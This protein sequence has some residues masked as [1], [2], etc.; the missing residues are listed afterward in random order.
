MK[1]LIVDDDTTNQRILSAYLKTDGNWVVLAKNGLEAVEL[2]Q[3]ESPELILM[4]VIMP[5]MDGYEATK[6]IKSMMADRF[7]PIIFLTPTTDE[8]VLTRCIEVGGDDFLTKPYNRTL[9]TAKID[10]L[11]RVNQLYNMVYQ[12]KQALLTHQALEAKEHEVARKVFD[13][14]LSSGCLSVENIQ[15]HLSPMSLFNGDVVLAAVKPTG[16]MHILLGDFTGHGLAASLGALPLS[17]VFYSMTSKGYSISDMVREINHKL[18]V[19]LPIGMFLAACLIEIDSHNKVLKYWNGAIPGAFLQKGDVLIE[20]CSKNLPLGILDD[21]CFIDKVDLIELNDQDRIILSTD[22]ILEAENN[23]GK[24]FGLARFKACLHFDDN[25]PLLEP[26]LLAKEADLFHHILETLGEFTQQQAQTDD[27]TLAVINCDMDYINQLESHKGAYKRFV[28]SHWEFSLTFYYDAIKLID[29]IP[30]INQI[31]SEIQGYPIQQDQLSQILT[32]LLGHSL[33][34]NLLKLDLNNKSTPNGF[35]QFCA[36]K[37]SRLQALESGSIKISVNNRPNITGGKL[38][39]IFENRGQG[40]N[41]SQMNNPI[42]VN[43]KEGKGLSLI[44]QYCDS[45]RYNK[46]GNKVEC[47]YLWTTKDS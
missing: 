11:K 13:S 12:Q 8:Q 40:V 42:N 2:F 9:L 17:D 47:V 46:A 30:L 26:Q 4:D 41:C 6:K 20:L 10:A 43:K 35:M 22:G 23:Q 18:K 14:I 31:M 34:H 16:G 45:I 25:N 44:N 32:E 38:T 15:L 5:V 28:S 33:D 36:D 39:I 29:P 3:T 27:V 21:S 19:Q 24:M 7:I 37:D 1:I